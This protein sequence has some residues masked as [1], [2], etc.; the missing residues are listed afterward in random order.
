MISRISGMILYWEK[1]RL[2]DIRIP[3]GDS[4]DFYS[5]R[6][7][8]ELKMVFLQPMFHWDMLIKMFCHVIYPCSID[9]FNISLTRMSIFS[10]FLKI[11]YKNIYTRVKNN[12][13]CFL[14]LNSVWVLFV[15][16]R[17]SKQFCYFSCVFKRKVLTVAKVWL[18][19]AC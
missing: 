14:R 16:E 9:I 11:V 5:E 13:K 7:S 1:Y 10:N 2:Y 12:F 17:C 6:Y 4:E 18:R 8:N 19:R 15:G 3:F